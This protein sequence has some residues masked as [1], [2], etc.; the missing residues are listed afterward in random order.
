[1]KRIEI[2]IWNYKTKAAEWVPGTFLRRISAID[3]DYRVECKTDDGRVYEGFAAAHP[4][5][6]RE[7]KQ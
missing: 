6:I 7:L 1:M 4:D 2:L 3:A 5:C